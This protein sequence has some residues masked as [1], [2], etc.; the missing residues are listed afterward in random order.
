M[1]YK[2]L[3]KEL[4]IKQSSIKYLTEEEVESLKSIQLIKEYLVTMQQKL[5]QH[6]TTHNADKNLLINGRNLTNVGVFRKYIQT[7][8]ENHS[9]INENMFLMARQLQPTAQGIPL[10]VYCFSKDKRWQNYEY[11]MSDLFDHF[12]AAVPYF[13]LEL[14]ELP[15]NSTFKHTINNLQIDKNS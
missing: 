13:G 11:V 15:D 10:E 1:M 9:A 5:E 3:P 14:F 12:L 8:L 2:P 7:Y 6:N 4:T